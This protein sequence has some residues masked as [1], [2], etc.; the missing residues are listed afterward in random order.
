MIADYPLLENY[1][2]YYRALALYRAKNFPAAAKVAETRMGTP[3]PRRHKR[4]L[5]PK[6]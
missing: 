6:R 3:R 4:K 1:H 2:R 5:H